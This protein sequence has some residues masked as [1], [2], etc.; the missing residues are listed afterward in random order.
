VIENAYLVQ[1]PSES[2]TFGQVII[3]V[4]D[5]VS[6][7]KDMTE[8]QTDFCIEEISVL[9]EESS[10]AQLRS[11]INQICEARGMQQI[12][13]EELLKPLEETQDAE[14]LKCFVSI[15][16]KFSIQRAEIIVYLKEAILVT[17]ETSAGENV[18]LNATRFDHLNTMASY[19]I[20]SGQLFDNAT[21]TEDN[22]KGTKIISEN[23]SSLENISMVCNNSMITDPFVFISI[24]V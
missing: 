12:V 5:A 3:K 4:T 20:T 7:G 19:N 1:S 2:P 10:Q 18:G 15:L 8:I 22:Y 13:E 6:E 9:E 23:V 14:L 17:E 11:L 24:I 16:E 21:S